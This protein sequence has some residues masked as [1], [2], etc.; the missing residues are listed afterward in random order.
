M[1]A[2]Y[3]KNRDGFVFDEATQTLMPYKFEEAIANF[4]NGVVIHKCTVDGVSREYTSDFEVYLNEE[5]FKKRNPHRG[6]GW[7]LQE[8][9]SQVYGCCL[10]DD[11]AAF[12]FINGEARLV[13][14]SVVDFACKSGTGWYA[15][16][17]EKFYA[18]PQRVYDFHDYKVKN[19]D[20]DV[21][22]VKSAHSRL[23]LT[24]EQMAVV[25]DFERAF[26]K[27]RELNVQMYYDMEGES[28]KFVNNEHIERTLW[29]EYVNEMVDMR[30]MGYD[31]SFYPISYNSC[32]YD[33]S[34]KMKQ[35]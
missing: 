2:I 1:N 33:L 12:A 27:L 28:M 17:G 3:I 14:V 8:V 5:E 21:R 16:N 6:S 25:L 29:G 31:I 13:D 34:V 26:K 30:G 10:H 4:N 32:D 24:D 9:V 23:S 22:V 7:V 15:P 20:G 19:E 35:L 18:T 11:V